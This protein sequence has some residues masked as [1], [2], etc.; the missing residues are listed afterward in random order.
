MINGIYS[1]AS[2]MDTLAQ[3]L[4]VIS[5]NLANVNTTGHRRRVPGVS[6]RFDAEDPNLNVD[7]GPEIT[8]VHR[9][10]EAGRMESTERPLDVAIRGDG[11]LVFDRNGKEFLTRNGRLFRDPDSGELVDNE[12]FPLLGENGPISVQQ[13][14]AD[15]DVTIAADGSVT[16][17]GNVVGKIQ[18]RSFEDNQALIA[19]GDSGFVA[20]PDAVEREST[21]TLGQYTLEL[22][23]VEPVSELIALIVNSRQ[24]Q[25]IERVTKTI[26]ET[27]SE[28]IR[29]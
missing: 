4:D 3:Q 5:N 8:E 22:S 27:L 23:N 16:I 21:A 11:F 7:L 28:Y 20:G 14:A 6:Q 29:S 18:L 1:G 12:G 10:F 9:K 19:D 15:L 26:S 2:A 24:H 13:D 25:A 17:L